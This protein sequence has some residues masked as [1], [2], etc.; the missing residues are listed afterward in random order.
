MSHIEITKYDAPAGKEY[1]AAAYPG[2]GLYIDSNFNYRL[3]CQLAG[4]A[5]ATAMYIGQLSPMCLK[6]LVQNQDEAK[7]QAPSSI[8]MNDLLKA[9]AISQKPDL[10]K[11][12]CQ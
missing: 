10:A 3:I 11:D 7:P 6:D 8:V 4:T 1:D 9:I 2:F 5:V 12:L